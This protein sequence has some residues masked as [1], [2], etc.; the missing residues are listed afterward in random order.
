MARKTE[1]LGHAQLKS[2]HEIDLLAGAASRP[3]TWR[4]IA[5]PGAGHALLQ[6]GTQ[7]QVSTVFG[8]ARAFCYCWRGGL[9]P[10]V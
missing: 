4:N 8:S 2:T 10:A 3:H 9:K 5:H 7:L 6:T 1:C